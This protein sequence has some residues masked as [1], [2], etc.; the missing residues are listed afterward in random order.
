M[1][2]SNDLC[3]VLIFVAAVVLCFSHT[4]PAEEITVRSKRGVASSIE[5]IGVDGDSLKFKGSR[6]TMLLPLKDF[7]EDSLI[8]IIKELGK[9]ESKDAPVVKTP[10]QPT[11][12]FI[13]QQLSFLS[14]GRPKPPAV[15]HEHQAGGGG[16]LGAIFRSLNPFG[17]NSGNAEPNAGKATET[18][19][20]RLEVFGENYVGKRV[21]F[22][23]AKFYGIFQ[24]RISDFP[25]VQIKTD[26]LITTY[27]KDEAAK[28]VNFAWDDAEGSTSWH[29]LA[30]KEQWAEF[31]LSLEKYEKV[32]IEGVVV[33]LP[34]DSAYGIIV[35]KVERVK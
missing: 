23:N 19:L 35:T 15:T 17:G 32:N 25:G 21:R 29:A 7:D 1:K 26:G 27:R 18:T 10:M 14:G 13:D 28:W 11:G 33:D 9:L 2:T 16:T 31:L 3:K 30:N 12:A 20:K 24:S 34:S 4:L 22:S 8:R 5:V 6:G